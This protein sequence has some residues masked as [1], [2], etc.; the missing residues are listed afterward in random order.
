MASGSS[1][2]QKARLKD[3]LDQHSEFGSLNDMR[4][5]YVQ[6]D[7]LFSGS[8]ISDSTFDSNDLQV[9]DFW[10]RV[11]SEYGQHVQNSFSFSLDQ[12]CHDLTIR[13]QI[14]VNVPLIVKN[15]MKEKMVPKSE[16][17]SKKA[18]SNAGWQKEPEKVEGTV[19]L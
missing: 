11:I 2:N 10:Q 9:I 5:Y 18:L 19:A 1:L 14:P 15:C 16:V 3:F 17:L 4:R 8:E 13:D 12:L 6:N 7:A